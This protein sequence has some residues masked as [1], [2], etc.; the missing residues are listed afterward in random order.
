MQ[1]MTVLAV[2]TFVWVFILIPLLIV[3]AIGVVDIV[4]RRDLSTAQTVGWII[5]VI[6]FPFLGTAVYWFLR[7]PTEKEI[8]QAQEAAAD[9]P[10]RWEGTHRRL[11]GE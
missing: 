4:R 7:K 6:L 11:P 5:V 2:S 9:L 8:E 3:W 10:E 1:G